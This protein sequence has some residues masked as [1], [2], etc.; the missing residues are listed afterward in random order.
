VRTGAA[1]RVALFVTLLSATPPGVA[2]EPRVG[3]TIAE[4]VEVADIEA[5]AVSPDGS[6]VA[7]R[8]ERASIQ[9]NGYDLDWYVA[10]LSTGAARRIGAGGEPI[11]NDGL[12]ES[13]RPIWSPDGRFIHYRALVDGA[14]GIWR[15]AADGSGARRVVAG[16]ADVESL[17]PSDDGA[18][19]LY[20]T[21]PT[22]A[23]VARS[24]RSEYDEGVLVDA[25][26]DPAQTLVR[27][28][29]VHGRLASQ[30]LVGH[31]YLRDGLLWRAPRVR[32]RID[33]R[34]M[35]EGPA[36]PLPPRTIAPMTVA[37]GN[38]GLSATSP[39]GLVATA[40]SENGQNR[41]E[42]RRG[43]GPRIECMAEA[44]RGPRVVSLAWRGADE[45][46]FT[47]QDRHHRQRLNRWTPRTGRVRTL[48]AGTGL[49]S[50]GRSGAL[51][52]AITAASAVCVT[53]SAVEPPRLERI[54]LDS[55]RRQALFDP[56]V[57]IRGRVAPRV[58]QLEWRL[59][60][61]RLATGTLLL[62]PRP[63]AAPAPLFL[64]YYYCPGFLRGGTGD[65]FP[66]TALVDAGF[67]VVCANVV[68]FEEWGDGADRYRAALA[69]VEALVDVLDR[70]G[71]IDRA[72]IGMGGFSAGSEATMWIAMNSRLLA[73]AAIASPQYEPSA[74][75]MSGVRGRDH[76]RV[77][78][79]FMQA[80]APDTDPDRWRTIA[81]ALN[82]ERISA[83][84]LMQLPEQE[85]RAA[86]ELY[87]RLSNTTTPVEMYAFPD[88]AHVKFQPRHR[89][90]IY[91]R[92]LDWFRYW[93]QGRV[94]PD[95]A[96]ADQY[97]RWD[98][99]RARRDGS[100][101]E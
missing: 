98:E 55:G 46:L 100:A 18:A 59:A 90:A 101:I 20:V 44:C 74:Y 9:R 50:G 8:V 41:L 5:L 34:T 87:A 14:I 27:G 69:S 25:S 54:D 21:G 62:P 92:H 91:R 30:R 86:M 26:V 53:A 29:W 2:A 40:R 33:L 45:L 51:P 64:T 3:P 7:F 85:M 60:D 1:L 10:D 47:T 72:L 42:V 78:R 93:L 70:R 77:M 80:G 84:L 19:L 32:R 65:P 17:A 71:L 39:G 48:H 68:P 38:A 56:N 88:E 95:P 6:M 79:E 16:D 15:A 57:A 43:E 94:D 23:E 82:T 22:R 11:Y 67:I 76:P 66:L 24:E 63:T 99:L 73:A 89:F 12:I 96:R 97:R 83:P 61:G 35:L 28:G 52:C 4:L 75:W 37:T 81:P 31:W 36:E 58:E 13:E 49:L